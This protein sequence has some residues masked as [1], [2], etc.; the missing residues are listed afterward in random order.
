LRL[1]SI[2]LAILAVPQPANA[3]LLVPYAGYTNGCFGACSPANTSAFQTAV[4]TKAN[5]SL[6]FVNSTFSGTATNTVYE[7]IG[8]PANGIAIQDVQN[9]GA[10][11]LT[12]TTNAIQDVY[13]DVFTLAVRWT[14]PGTGLGVFVGAI[15]GLIQF[16]NDKL[17][18]SFPT[19]TQTF[20]FTHPSGNQGT[21]NYVFKDHV[22]S[23]AGAIG[24]SPGVQIVGEAVVH[25]SPE[26]A[27]MTLLGS[28]LLGLVGVA[29][30]R[31]RQRE[32]ESLL[33]V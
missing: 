9:F 19:N 26:P 32:D 27:T 21:V 14:D 23:T 24:N 2:A 17:S 6:T 16:T 22:V 33:A 13:N 10:F 18:V 7:R 28:G 31:R 30:R 5:S 1:A 12:R 25:V 8:D 3:Q 15:S 11:Y 29:R 4:L 20:S